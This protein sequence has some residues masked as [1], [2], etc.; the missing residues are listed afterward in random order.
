MNSPQPPTPA[1]QS[2]DA[3]EGRMAITDF[4]IRIPGF[5]RSVDGSEPGPSR[6]KTK[7]FRFYYLVFAIVVPMMMRIPARLSSSEWNYPKYM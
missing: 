7:E 6:W 5:N 3:I 4:T 1:V 2:Q